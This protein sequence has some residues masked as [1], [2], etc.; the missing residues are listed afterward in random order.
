MPELII[1]DHQDSKRKEKLHI[2]AAKSK[3]LA[4]YVNI[5]ISKSGI[6]NVHNGQD[7]GVVSLTSIHM[8]KDDLDV[9]INFLKSIKDSLK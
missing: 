8:Y 6:K 3:G 4:S 7:F 5:K 2:E 1:K 9:L